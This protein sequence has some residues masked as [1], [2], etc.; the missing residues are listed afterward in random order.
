MIK[1][2]SDQTAPPQEQQ[3][4]NGSDS[5]RLLGEYCTWC[6]EELDSEERENPERD[7]RGELMCD[8][9]YDEEYMGYCDRCGEKRAKSELEANPGDLIAIWLTA[10]GA[11]GNLAPGYYRVNG[12]P[13]FA[14]G[15]IE[16]Y[17]YNDRLDRVADLDEQGKRV[18][19]DAYS[20]SGPLCSCC[21]TKVDA[22]LPPN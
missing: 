22:S 19:E 14:D 1:Q 17:F 13:F 10:P 20:L 18:A 3:R 9:C 12:W 5:T 8:E 21:R 4:G 7:D 15:M 11:R 16:G 2:Q 6:G